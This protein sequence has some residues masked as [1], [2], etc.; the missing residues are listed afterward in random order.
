LTAGEL[1]NADRFTAPAAA[2]GVVRL[3]LFDL[4]AAFEVNHSR[5]RTGHLSDL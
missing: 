4:E 3:V 1:I 2:R 5:R